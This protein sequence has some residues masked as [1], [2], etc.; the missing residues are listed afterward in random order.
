MDVQYIKNDIGQIA[1]AVV[2]IDVWES[3]LSQA[4]EPVVA[5]GKIEEKPFDLM[6]YFGIITIDMPD[7][8]LFD[9]LNQLR[10]EWDRDI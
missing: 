4:H 5:Y 10:S 6:D 2:P 7:E 3:T 8:Q 9:E 1:Y